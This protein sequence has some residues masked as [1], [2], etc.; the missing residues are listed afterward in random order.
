MRPAS[1]DEN[2]IDSERRLSSW[3]Y[4]EFELKWEKIDPNRPW[5][6]E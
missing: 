4:L 5:I 2:E 3:N 1:A 6:D